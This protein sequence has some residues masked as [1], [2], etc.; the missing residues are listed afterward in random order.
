MYYQDLPEDFKFQIFEGLKKKLKA[1]GQLA[2]EVVD[3]Y[4]NCRNTERNVKKWVND[5]CL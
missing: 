2:F 1:R 3:E 4:I 5:Y